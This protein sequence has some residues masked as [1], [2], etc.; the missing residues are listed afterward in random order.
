MAT[1]SYKIDSYTIQLY[2]NDLRGSLT[3]WAAQVIYLYSGGKHIA[4][5]FFAR[6][7]TNAPDAVF[8][9]GHIYF[10]AQ[11]EQF[12]PVVDLLRNEKPV[13]ISW[14]PFTDSS[15]PNDGNAYFYCGQEPVGEGE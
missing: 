2:A 13:Y 14:V 5:A 10:H 1:T 3:R 11:G 9:N 8:S 7:G 12:E 4:S 15:E 6:A